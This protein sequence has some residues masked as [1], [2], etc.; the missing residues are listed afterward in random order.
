MSMV[1]IWNMLYKYKKTS[2]SAASGSGGERVKVIP[3]EQAD[4]SDKRYKILA[5]SLEGVD[6]MPDKAVQHAQ[7]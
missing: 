7:G 2:D 4:S 3:I 5:S 6:L 1:P